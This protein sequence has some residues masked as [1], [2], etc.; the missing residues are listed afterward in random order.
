[1]R[2]YELEVP[3]SKNNDALEKD[4]EKCISCGY[5]RKVCTNDITVARI[6]E[7]RKDAEPIC[8]DCGQCANIC[9][10]EA[11]HEKFD[12]KRVKK[13]LHNKNGKTIIFSVAPA[14]R[15]ALGEDLGLNVGINVEKKIPAM[16]K[17]L[18][19]DYVFDITFGADLTIMEEAME[20]VS[21]IKNKDKLPMFTSCCPA[22]VKYAEIFYPELLPNL[23]TAKSPISIQSAIIKTFFAKEKGLNPEDIIHIVIAPC[24]AKKAEIKREELKPQT[25]YILTTR[26]FANL[27]K[28]EQVDISNIIDNDFDIPFETGAGSGVLFGNSGGV[29]E[30]A[31]RTAYYYLTGKNLTKEEL[32]FTELRGMKG[33]KESKI[34]I[35]DKTIKVVACNGMKNAKTIIDKVIKKESD[36]DFI[37][38]MNC[39]GGCISGG[40][41]PKI[42]MLDMNDTKVS[43]MNS[44]YDEDEIMTLRLCHENPEIIY[45]Y[46]K[47]LEKPNSNLSKELLHTTYYNKSYLIG[48]END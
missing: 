37:E 14:V 30:A 36:Y 32:T 7:I 6:F 44:I 2:N 4:D 31:L 29:L 3:I 38:V 12:Y 39:F 9:P 42:T 20:F 45:I 21:R 16:L 8:V 26:E 19:A 11:I 47:Y 24:T 13:I 23:S 28:E 48:G 35:N 41:Q 46:E 40:G 18:G 5:C 43:R 17:K 27:L 25:D 33:I 22:W 1:M 34:I 10:T 15:V